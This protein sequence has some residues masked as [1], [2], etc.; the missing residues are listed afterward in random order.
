MTNGEPLLR[1]EG[2]QKSFGPTRALVHANLTVRPGAVHALLGGNGAGKS[3]LINV[4]SGELEPDAGSLNVAVR[5]SSENSVV[6]V[7]QELAVMPQLTVAENVASTH[8]RGHLF[9]PRSRAR[10]D[11][12]AALQALG[13]DTIRVSP[14]RKA[15]ELA[16]HELQLMEIARAICTG[17]RLIL[18]DEPTATLSSDEAVRL[19]AVMRR[20]ATDGYG[21]VFVSHRMQE[22]REIAEVVTV[23]RDGRTVVD[24][25]PI[26]EISD[27]EILAAMAPADAN[28][29][30]P[31]QKSMPTGRCRGSAARRLGLEHSSTH[32]QTDVAA[33]E[34]LGLAGTAGGP[35]RLLDSFLGLVP[36]ASWRIEMDGRRLRVK[37][38]RHAVKQGIGYASGD[39][40]SKGLMPEL[41]IHENIVFARR[42]VEGSLFVGSDE[43]RQARQLLDQLGI[44]APDVEAAPS[45]LSGGTQQKLL[46][47]RWLSMPLRLL[48]L[49]EPT[50]GVDVHTKRDIYQLI[51]EMA[52]R[53]ATVLWWST[54]QAELLDVCDRILTF[55]IT[56]RPTAVINGADATDDQI[57]AETGVAS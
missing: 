29:L 38:P 19:F 17:A 26:A 47:A 31:A 5:E 2:I 34:V 4:I 20:L 21:L 14:D 22:I 11:T 1:A 13:V 24:A 37:S 7:H 3:T 18:L 48:L 39:R 6:V 43:R 27:S 57:M 10:R 16:L 32:F 53:G 8:L 23:M 46:L 52:E 15:D 54:E 41:S 40:A 50:R 33:G 25:M 36:N 44:K 28:E 56:G 42:V 30:L 35:D 55:S 51:H 45:T 12:V 9:Y 49:E